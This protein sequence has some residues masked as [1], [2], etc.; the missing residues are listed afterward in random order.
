[1]GEEL[2]KLMKYDV[3][4]DNFDNLIR[5]ENE[6]NGMYYLVKDV[7]K[8]INHRPTA[9]RGD[10]CPNC[11]GAP[12]VEELKCSECGHFYYPSHP[13]STKGAENEYVATKREKVCLLL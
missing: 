7:E 2:K 10:A 11:G 5:S 6:E 1:M 13:N 12:Q 3:Y 4:T 8:L 9:T